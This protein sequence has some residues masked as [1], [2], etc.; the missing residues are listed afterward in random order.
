M[1]NEK[2]MILIGQLG[3]NPSKYISQICH[4]TDETCS[5]QTNGSRAP[6][7]FCENDINI[8]LLIFG[9]RMIL[10]EN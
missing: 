5:E 10:Y 1:G 3:Y 6:F 7:H 4:L 2:R 9:E 8:M